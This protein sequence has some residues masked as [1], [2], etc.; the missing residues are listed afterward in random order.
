MRRD[1]LFGSTFIC[2]SIAMFVGFCEA[3]LVWY[4]D[5]RVRLICVELACGHMTA[6]D[7]N[8]CLSDGRL[9]MVDLSLLRLSLVVQDSRPWTNPYIMMHDMFRNRL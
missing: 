3:T 2:I 1:G 4:R 7:G 6:T 8:V 9:S 5:I